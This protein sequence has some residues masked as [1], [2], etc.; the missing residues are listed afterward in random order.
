MIDTRY[1]DQFRWYFIRN[2]SFGGWITL[3]VEIFKWDIDWSEYQTH[4]NGD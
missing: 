4:G 1:I 2:I 3:P